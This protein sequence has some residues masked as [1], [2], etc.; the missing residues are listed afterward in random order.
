MSSFFP[1]PYPDELLYSV[2]ARCAAWRGVNSMKRFALLLFGTGYPRATVDLPNRLDALAERIPGGSTVTPELLIERNTLFP[3]YR[4]FLPKER[5]DRIVAAMRGDDRGNIIH[6]AIGLRASTMKAPRFLRYCP[7]CIAEDEENH[8]EPYWHRVHQ[9]PGVHVCPI[10]ETWLEESTVAMASPSTRH[11]FYALGESSVQKQERTCA[12]PSEEDLPRHLAVARGALD[13]LEGNVPSQAPK[14]LRHMY[15]YHL[16]EKGFASVTGAVKHSDFLT[17]FLGYYGSSFLEQVY[18]PVDIHQPHNWLFQVVRTARCVVH[19]LR[20]ILVMNFLGFLPAEFFKTGRQEYQPF[21]Q[22][23]WPCLNKIAPHYGQ[24]IITTCT[25]SRADNA[26]APVGHFA[27]PQCGL[28]YT[29]RGPDRLEEDRYRISRLM[30]L[31]PFWEA[32]FL[33]IASDESLSSREIARRLHVDVGTI[34]ER[35]KRLCGEGG[36]RG[37][38]GKGQQGFEKRRAIRRER[39]L[40]FTRSHPGL[41]RKQLYRL[42]PQDFMWLYKNDRTWLWDQLPKPLPKKKYADRRVDWQ[43][44]DRTLQ[45]E[46]VRAAAEIRHQPGKP[47]R[48]TARAVSDRIGSPAILIRRYLQNLPETSAALESVVESVEDFQIRRVR[49]TAA[50]LRN[51][52]TPLATWRILKAAGIKPGCSE[53]VA[54]DIEKALASAAATTWPTVFPPAL[55][56]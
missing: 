38:N 40:T 36:D 5:A 22:G 11:A 25:I 4:S 20:H 17:S 14:E 51:V 9:V 18:S 15:V 54:E 19:P 48:V 37:Q 39:W 12:T 55:S 53:R 28:V 1:T 10:H 24:P 27:C 42:A 56:S 34:I 23:P 13:L 44:R 3:L 2:I 16:R 29:R 33:R 6:G 30:S 41:N 43:E 52:G 49:Y 45:Q 47:V 35:R 7:K 26:P 46:V 21:G 50:K 8:G 31:G 32:Q